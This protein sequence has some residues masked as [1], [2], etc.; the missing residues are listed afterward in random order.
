MVDLRSDTNSRAPQEML[1]AM[2]TAEVGDDVFSDDPTALKLE[3]TVAQMFG[4]QAGLLTPSVTMSNAIAAIL[5]GN[6]GDEVILWEKSHF[7]DR[8]GGN[9]ALLAGL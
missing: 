8:E 9:L 5:S 6:P 4:K 3:E 7:S 1:E 2:V